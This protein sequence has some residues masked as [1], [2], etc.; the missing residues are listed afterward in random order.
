MNMQNEAGQGQE[1]GAA[2]GA[3]LERYT[4]ELG[5]SN[6]WAL[7][8]ST[9]LAGGA[10]HDSWRLQPFPPV[11]ERA[12][13]SHKW[14]V[15]GRRYLD[16][17]MGHGA[18]L[19]GN[20]HPAVVDAV[21]RQMGRGQH[22]GGVHALQYAWAER[23]QR[24]M[25]SCERIRFTSSGTEATMLALR[26]A[27]AWTGRGRVLRVD[28]H[29]HGWH[30][31]ALVHALP[32]ERAGFNWGVADYVA[33]VPPLDVD[34]VEAELAANDVAALILEPG[35]G[36]AGSLPW[37]GEYLAAL[38]KLAD[39]H[40]TALIFDEVIS[41]FRY[42]PGGVQALAGV[43]PDITVLA[44]IAAGGMP[45]ALVGGRAELMAVLGGGR[46]AGGD[47]AYVP[48]SGTFNGLPLSAAAALATLALVDD[49]QAA[50]RAEQSAAE[51][52]AGIN[53][54]AEAAGVDVR[55]FH[56]SSI[57]HLL[58]GAVGAGLPL[59]AGPAA[60]RLPRERAPLYQLLRAA[61]LLEGVDCHASH[62][63]LS[64]AHDGA[65]I[66]EAIAGFARAFAAVARIDAFRV[67][68]HG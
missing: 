5:A 10:P 22:V 37:S 46:S 6:P 31:E 52:V 56:Q 59:A 17:W 53:A 48:H 44:K 27:R 29:F 28:G 67:A 34:A 58:I 33:L 26:L 49:G 9:L 45:G 66:A 40:G 64:A 39:Q 3:L 21:A 14:D 54:A 11:F 2:A 24:S 50:R 63:W 35:G 20:A 51:L 12:E 61:L 47:Y 60:I 23:I 15:A 18:L 36:S 42:G 68:S 55:A 16:L 19:L 41:G 7:A 4:R 8:Q 30:D 65:D 38:R 32:A 62:G 13:G 57:F 25:P 1:H 43:R